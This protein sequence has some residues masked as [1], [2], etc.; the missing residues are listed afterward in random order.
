MTHIITRTEKIIGYGVLFCIFAY[1]LWR[2][3][4]FEIYNKPMST[5]NYNLYFYMFF[6]YL[7][8][9]SLNIVREALLYIRIREMNVQVLR[10]SSAI[11]E[12]IKVVIGLSSLVVYWYFIGKVDIFYIPILAGIYGF[13]L[14][15]IMTKSVYG[16]NECLVVEGK[17]I[18]Y[19]QFDYYEEEEGQKIKLYGEKTETINSIGSKSSNIVIAELKKRIREKGEVSEESA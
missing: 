1:G 10:G 3:A 16:N 14:P 9:Y 19:D 13:F 7:T 17:V 12:I 4:T 8:I 11:W 15:R 2:S 5:F 18:N 6:V